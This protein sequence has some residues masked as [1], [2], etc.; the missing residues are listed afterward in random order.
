MEGDEEANDIIKD[1]DHM[2]EFSDTYYEKDVKQ[3][4][5]EEEDEPGKKDK[6]KTN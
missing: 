4:S 1:F 6:T 2:N 3:E 5:E